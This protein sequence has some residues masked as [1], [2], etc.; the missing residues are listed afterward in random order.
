MGHATQ[1]CIWE[2]PAPWPAKGLK[3][4]VPPCVLCPCLQDSA[5]GRGPGHHTTPSRR[6]ALRAG[7]T[8]RDLSISRPGPLVRQYCHFPKT[9]PLVF[10]T[11]GFTLCGKDQLSLDPLPDWRLILCFSLKSAYHT[12]KVKVAQSFLTLRSCGPSVHGNLQARILE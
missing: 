4:S 12:L 5:A 6:G 2:R 3:A 11:E 9:R 10:S 1:G 8:E 7:G